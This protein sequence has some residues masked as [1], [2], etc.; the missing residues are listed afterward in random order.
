MCLEPV[1]TEATVGNEGHTEGISVLHLLD[2]DAFHDLFLV[3]IDGEVEFVVYNI[4]DTLSSM[5]R[6]V[7]YMLDSYFCNRLIVLSSGNNSNRFF[8]QL[9]KSGSLQTPFVQV[10]A[11]VWVLLPAA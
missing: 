9:M 1:G 11:P 4:S 8:T 6:I 3:R 5:I 7:Y 2:D 10:P